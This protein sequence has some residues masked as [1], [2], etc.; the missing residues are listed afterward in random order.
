[1][2]WEPKCA[3]K[4]S[5]YWLSLDQPAGQRIVAENNGENRIEI[6][7]KGNA[8]G[9]SLMLN[10]EMIDLKKKVIVVLNGETVHEDF[11]FHSAAALLSSI[12][13]RND[14]NMVFTARLDL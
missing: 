10:E 12:A 7:V 1:M 8:A 2:V 6:T 13:G 11:V 14:R 3:W 9:L 5:F 4:T